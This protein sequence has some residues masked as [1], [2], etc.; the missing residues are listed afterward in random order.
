MRSLKFLLVLVSVVACT[1]L[2]AA[3][4]LSVRDLTYS[5]IDIDTAVIIFNDSI[6]P[7][8]AVLADYREGRYAKGYKLIVEEPIFVRME[9]AGSIDTYSFLFDETFNQIDCN[10][11]YNGSN[12]GYCMVLEAGVY[13]WAVTT[14]SKGYN[15]VNLTI[16]IE[17]LNGVSVKDLTYTPMNF[18]TPIED[19]LTANDVILKDVR[20]GRH[21]QGYTFT[22]KD[23]N[24]VGIDI[25]L[26]TKNE[27]NSYLYLL[28]GHFN[29]ITRNDDADN[30][31]QIS[32]VLGAGK[33]Y[34]VVT[35]YR[36]DEFGEYS[37]TLGKTKLYTYNEIAYTPIVPDTMLCD[38]I[39]VNSKNI[40]LI[41]GNEVAKANGY[42][43][44]LL[45]GDIFQM[46]LKYGYMPFMILDA[47]Y[48]VLAFNVLNDE[49]VYNYYVEQS[50]TYYVLLMSSDNLKYNISF[51]LKKQPE[52]QVYFVDAVNGSNS[53]NGTGI[54][55]AFASLDYVM[56]NF[57]DSGSS[58]VCYL[59]SDVKLNVGKYTREYVILSLLPYEGKN[60]TI[61]SDTLIRMNFNYSCIEIGHKDSGS[62][63][64]TQIK[65]TTTRL[66]K[67]YEGRL[68]LN[69]VN[70]NNIKARCIVESQ[71]ANV[72]L[73][74]C[75]IEN[76]TIEE[77]IYCGN[78]VVSCNNSRINYNEGMGIMGFMECV[79][80]LNNTTLVGNKSYSPVIVAEEAYVYISN[81][82]L[83]DNESHIF[84]ESIMPDTTLT[85]E[86]MGGIISIM[87]ELHIKG[88]VTM[89]DNYIVLVNGSK[90]TID[91]NITSEKA[92]VI[93]PVYISEFVESP[94]A[95]KSSENVGFRYNYYEGDCVLTGNVY[96]NYKRFDLYQPSN[97]TIWYIISDGTLSMREDVAVEEVAEDNVDIYPNPTSGMLYIH[98]HGAEVTG[99]RLVDI[100][101]RILRTQR[102]QDEN[103]QLNMQSLAHGMY[104]VQLMNQQGVLATHKVIK[105]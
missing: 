37:L 54:N 23:E 72:E 74:N 80:V 32:K 25:I 67:M 103:I 90:V 57:V 22:I 16:T 12:T 46:S 41:D 63:T 3:D 97:D 81:S 77:Y 49:L 48:N 104:F 89:H 56:E 83:D 70:V 101:G 76:N 24:Y 88:N 21:A 87:A 20:A 75:N 43:V 2:K 14:Y 86:N 102:V 26:D 99:I 65:D 44:S 96:P 31:S 71:G 64:F 7:N 98:T 38:S 5:T 19:S 78:G 15:R 105:K 55:D 53:N 45:Q 69:N 8:D 6:T 42:C 50:G 68:K 30:G 34:I 73:N 29:I 52:S 27:W 17:L 61:S 62:I 95:L 33:Y 85:A 91:D 9:A 18:C 28:D 100:Q 4:T 82:T 60:I 11:D 40:C 47:D 10:D 92:G 79:S 39:T 84:E 51:T 13:Y 66:I 94:R 93:L 59:M 1:G 36:D 58:I 35:Q